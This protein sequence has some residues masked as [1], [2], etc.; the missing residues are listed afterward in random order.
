MATA[1]AEL[2]EPSTEIGY[3]FLTERLGDDM[4][5]PTYSMYLP[6][7]GVTFDRNSSF[8]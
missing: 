6:F 8:L 1:P 2:L 4:S 3:E 5:H 7:T